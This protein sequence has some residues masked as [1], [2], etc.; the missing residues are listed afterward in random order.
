M[1]LTGLVLLCFVA[2]HMLGNLQI[3]SGPSELNAYGQLLHSIPELL[4]VV[5]VMLISC[6]IIHIS[7]GLGLWVHNKRARPIGYATRTTVGSTWAS[8]SMAL[9]GIIVLV[10]L[11]LHILH[12]TV[13]T[14]DPNYLGYKDDEGR[15]DIFRMLVEAFSNPWFAWFYVIGVG[16]LCLHLSHGISSLFRSLGWVNTP[17]RPWQIALAYGCS[18]LLFVGFS[19]VPL[20]IQFGFVTLLSP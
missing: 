19:A 8:R 5:R 6:V 2:G 3:F 9:S 16:L 12:F 11:T 4:W 10:F 14:I 13:C 20:S 18:V 7:A 1:G 15:H 17:Y